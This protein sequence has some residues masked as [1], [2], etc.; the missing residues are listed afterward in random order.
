MALAPTLTDTDGDGEVDY[1]SG[2]N[3]GAVTQQAAISIL[4]SQLTTDNTVATPPTDGTAVV[5]AAI[6][7]GSLV[8]GTSGLT[9]T[10]FDTQFTDVNSQF[11]TI[12]EAGGLAGVFNSP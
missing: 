8:G 10:G 3:S 11:S 6:A 12:L 4:V 7:D 2:V 1:P 5:A 9:F